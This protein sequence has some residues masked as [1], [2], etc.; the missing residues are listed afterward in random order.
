MADACCGPD[1]ATTPA[2][3]RT[4]GADHDPPTGPGRLRDVHELR[5]AVLAG[6]FLVVG[7]L[8]G[9]SGAAT[10]GTV[11]TVVA[12]LVGGSTFVPDSIRGLRHRRIGVGTL[13]TIAAVGAVVLGELGEAAGL[14]FLFSISE[15]LEGYSVARTRQGLRSLLEL[16]PPTA[17]VLRDGATV[18]V[19]PS[20]LAVGDILVVRPGERLATD[21]VVVEGRSAVDVA[22]IT[23]ESVPVEIG[24]GDTVFAATINGGGALE[25]RVT[26]TTTDNSLARI[27]HI[28]EEAQDR[29]G[30]TQRLADR[31]AS[32]LVPGV[33]VLA[34]A[35]AV[36]GSLL[37][38]PAVWIE[39]ALVVLVAAAP[40]AMAL[41]VPV[42]VVAAI[43][44][45]SRSGV[46]VKGGAALEALGNVT[47][48][49]LDKTGTLTRNAPRVIEVVT[50]A[51]CARDDV[52][53]DAAAIE[54]RSEHPLAAAITAAAPRLATAGGARA[55]D[56]TAIPGSGLVGTVGS[57]TI[58]VGRPGFV[59]VDGME[60]DVARLQG[61]GATT[62]AV[63]VDGSP[64]GLIAVR[65][66]LR[67]EAAE[68]VADLH[69]MGLDVRMLTGDNP[70]TARALG[71]TA[72]IGTVHADLR[73]EDKSAR[74]TTM[75]EAGP[76]AMVGD[77]I[78][79][80]PAL[81]VAD[82]GIAMGAMGADVAIETA[83]VALLG[84]DLRSLAA[85]IAH[86]R[87]ARRIMRQNLVMSA[88][89]IAVLVPL[90]AAGALGLAAV[91]ATHELA[92]VVV[93]ANG[94]RAGRSRR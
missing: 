18:Q 69:R 54:S 41:S 39:R 40:C 14:A 77:G 35:V 63:E 65:D 16:T 74:V 24:P 7:W 45:A 55:A 79:D 23:G 11:A 57:R 92:E 10:A 6:V 76:V 64:T 30:T 56:V 42:A 59:P 33:M 83:D 61:A 93:I 89:I 28:V 60:A 78:N 46:L 70:L 71:T 84:E 94:V 25:V 66:E 53:A 19:D 21:G 68:A 31:V 62:V 91:V 2:T 90:S 17:E 5:M 3:D 43:G 27:V 1:A 85:A 80:A 81:A 48:V 4:G 58:R 12:L 82:V 51:G 13:M 32:P 38:D 52:L 47:A 44:S 88:A 20:E 75:R 8:L 22:A 29:K 50:A 73:P 36:I 72:G 15:G 87:R 34:A 49:A 26:A 9:R 67:P 37:G 86:A